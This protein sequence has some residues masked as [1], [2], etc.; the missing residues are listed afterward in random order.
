MAARVCAA[1]SKSGVQ[2]A[3]S[4][5][6]NASFFG[7]SRIGI[8]KS[9][10]S[11]ARFMS[12]EPI[13]VPKVNN[14][15]PVSNFKEEIRRRERVATTWFPYPVYSLEEFKQVGTCQLASAVFQ[16][17]L[18][19]DILNRVVLWQRAGWRTIA[20]IAKN[21]N[22]VSG[23]GKKPWAQK[24]TGRARQGSIRAPH[25]RHG[26]KAH[27]PVQRSFAIDM[28]KKVRRLGVRVAMSSRMREGKV[29]IVE[30]EKLSSSK[31]RHAAAVARQWGWDSCLF[32]TGSSPDKNFDLATGNL[33]NLRAIPAHKTSVYTILKHKQLVITKEA[34]DLLHVH[35]L[36][37]AP[38]SSLLLVVAVDEEI[39]SSRR[40]SSNEDHYDDHLFL[41]LTIVGGDDDGLEDEE[42]C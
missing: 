30:S 37:W 11:T 16:E 18:R 31:T 20:R 36:R 34:V 5:R 6:K 42:P 35:L 32:I 8:L 23:G 12:T 41:H 33:P 39:H 1:L 17:P 2:I 22:M 3:R 38:A 28:P 13:L 24:K 40:T 27:G 7:A 19:V 15:Y 4:F 10:G 9:Y 29:W 21:R 14:I 25:F 26:G